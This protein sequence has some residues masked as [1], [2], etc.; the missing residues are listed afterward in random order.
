[1]FVAYGVCHFATMHYYYKMFWLILI[2]GNSYDKA[3]NL[4]CIISH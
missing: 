2:G 1:M 3:K 4:G